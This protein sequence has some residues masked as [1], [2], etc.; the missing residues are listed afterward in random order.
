[1]IQSEQIGF[2]GKR[3]FQVRYAFKKGEVVYLGLTN[4]HQEEIPQIIASSNPSSLS[5]PFA[6]A[7]VVFPE[8]SG[9]DSNS[10]DQLTQAII[11]GIPPYKRLVLLMN[12]D[13]LFSK[14]EELFL[15]RLR[16]EILSSKRY[17]SVKT[18][19]SMV[20]LFKQFPNHFYLLRMIPQAIFGFLDGYL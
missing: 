1:M 14:V 16:M 10:S 20:E 11:D 18:T 19:N 17:K 4:Q 13:H 8:H 6:K 9:V 2:L 12:N 15:R 3:I 5:K 7:E